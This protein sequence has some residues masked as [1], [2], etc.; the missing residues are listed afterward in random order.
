M[1]RS[2]PSY[3]AIPTFV[4]I[5]WEKTS[6]RV[7]GVHVEIQTRNLHNTN[8]R[9]YSLNQPVWYKIGHP[10]IIQC[11]RKHIGNIW[12]HLYDQESGLAEE[13]FLE[14]ETA[15]RC[16]PPV[17]S[18]PSPNSNNPPRRTARMQQPRFELPWQLQSPSYRRNNNNTLDNTKTQ[19]FS[20][21]CQHYGN[22]LTTDIKIEIISVPA[23]T[24]MSVRVE[25]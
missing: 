18:T 21:G 22:N 24:I 23:P 20:K 5:D 14:R 3:Y 7:T 15:S 8:S 11:F 9:L 16:N 19:C 10:R 12:D 4:F 13:T 17:H 2:W 25:R 1:K 6:V